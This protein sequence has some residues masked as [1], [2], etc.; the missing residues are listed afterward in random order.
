MTYLT[1]ELQ[2]QDKKRFIIDLDNAKQ[3]TDSSGQHTRI[4]TLIFMAATSMLSIGMAILKKD[5]ISFLFFFFL[6]ITITS[7]RQ[8]NPKA[9]LLIEL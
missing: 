2:K 5:L 4:R 6:A 3:A 7:G 9:K 8:L 1:G